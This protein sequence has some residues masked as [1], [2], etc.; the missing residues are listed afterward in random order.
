[1][2][3]TLRDNILLF[4]AAAL[5]FIPF[6]GAV[7]LFDW[8]E[9]NFAESAREMIVTKNYFLVEIN[10]LPFWE[11]PPLFIWMQVLSMRI[12]GINEFA[13]RF[14]NAV[15]GIATLLVLFNI[16]ARLKNERFGILWALIYAGSFLPQFYFKS[17]II[18][19][20][21]NLFTFLGVFYFISLAGI[22]KNLVEVPGKKGM[23]IL[24]ALCIGLAILAKGPVALLILVLCVF[25]YWIMSR[26]RWMI[27]LGQTLWWIAIVFLVGGFWFLLLVW[28]GN[29]SLIKEFINYQVRLFTTGD[30]GHGG[31][32]FYHWIV[33]LIGCFPMSVFALQSFRK[34]EH[35]T[36]VELHFRQWMLILFWV[37]LI[38]FSIVRTKIVHYS[39]LCYF[40][41]S[42][43][44]GDVVF[45]LMKGQLK[46]SRTIGGILM[47][48]ATVLGLLISSL[49]I[50]DNF[51]TQIIRANIIR[52]SFAAASLGANVNWTGFE[53]L[54]GTWLI[55]GTACML[56]LIRRKKI[57]F[58]VVGMFIIS[59]STANIAMTVIVPRIEK[60]SQGAAIQFYKS[61]KTKD[62]Y[63]TTLGFKS[64]A[65]LFYQAKKPPNN[66]NSYDRDWL[67][68]GP[69]DKPAYFVCKINNVEQVM[70]ENPQL[71]KLYQRNGFVF[72]LRLPSRPFA[73]GSQLFI[74]SP[75]QRA[76]IACGVC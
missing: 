26:F 35:D 15:C 13:A 11:K 24:S 38:L 29:G 65:Q 33:L 6:L 27:S 21:F 45:R 71:I 47:L 48:L 54:V 31:T 55:I 28:T 73:S 19:P 25:V 44:A 62:C 42:F 49:P 22:K 23:V 20:W 68:R 43:L 63:V 10:Y 74:K 8:D 46:W 58:G 61:L 30:A 69:I 32:F 4:G 7:H 34:Y 66:K 59:L 60:Y 56:I 36:P 2:S 75:L 41:L 76:I 50:I 1:M 5:L 53:W 37:V 12:F 17:G 9:I 67:L 72:L 39:S 18:D 16:G 64:Y 3:K 52:D 40:P 14:P 70:K 57:V 51:K